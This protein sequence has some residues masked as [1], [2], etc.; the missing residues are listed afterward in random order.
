MTL[1]KK[2][3]FFI[4][5]MLVLFLLLWS[6]TL[7]ADVPDGFT[8]YGAATDIS[9]NDETLVFSYYHEG[10][11]ALYTVPVTGG[12][13]E[14]LAQPDEGDSYINPKFSPDGEAITFVRQWEEEEGP[15]GE[16]MLMDL[17]T[18]EVEELTSGGGLVTEAVF[19]PDGDVIYFLQ[20]GV[21]ENYSPIAQERPHGF[22]IY[23]MDL[24]TKETQQ[25]TNKDAYDMSALAVTP[26]GEQLMFKSYDQSDRIIFISLENNAETSP[27]PIGDFASEAPIISSPAL[28]PDGEQ[29]AFSDVT[30]TDENGTFIYEAFL[31]DLNNYQAEPITNF[32]EHVTEPVFFHEG[33]KL[34]VTLDKQFAQKETD[35]QYWEINIDGQE[36]KRLHIEMPENEES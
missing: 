32:R 35:Y 14:L 13:A 7:F 18:N 20:A 19:S 11:A 33:D 8:G 15:H 34:I 30:A 9:P 31:M 17:A 22:D 6:A 4:S 16:V 29:I 2:N 3:I 5:G 21:F 12:K 1:K 23:Q 36:Q 10:E 26:D 25:I 28:S 24:N 27:V